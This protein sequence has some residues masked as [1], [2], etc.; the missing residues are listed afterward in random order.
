M[1]KS[2]RVL[3]TPREIAGVASGLQDTLGAR[4][5]E[6]DV[7]LRWTHP[8]AYALRPSRSYL[9]RKLAP[10]VVE[11]EGSSVAR[12]R[13]L[14][15]LVARVMLLP[16]LAARYDAVVFLGQDTFVRGGWDRRLLGRLGVRI[17]TVFCGSE[18]RPPYLDGWYA[19]AGSTTSLDDARSAVTR[20]RERVQ[21]AERDSAAVVNHAGG[22]QFHT[23]PFLDWAVVGFA[24]RQQVVSAAPDSSSAR[25]GAR[26]RVLHAPSDPRMK[27]THEIRAA[28]A[29]LADEGIEFDYVEVSGRSHTEVLELLRGADL[30]VDQLYSDALLPGLAT[31]AA[32]AGTAVLVLGYASGLVADAAARTGAPTAHY[33]H[34]DDLLPR[35]RR[36]LTDSEHRASMAADLHAF[37]TVGHWSLDAIGQRWER[38]VAGDADPDWYDVPT[39]IVYADGCAVSARDDAIFLRRYVERFGA[40]ALELDHHPRL[41]AALLA[42]V[43][44]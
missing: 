24:Q 29:A 27:G 17:I 20:T 26:L 11:T 30:V 39:E 36:L 5:H 44:G 32:R 21:Q 9:L 2:L 28:M 43:E 25:S 23:R 22:A 7:L 41:A 31:E 19:G 14:V 8:F 37:V 13:R 35:V 10:L 6:V 3:V 18:A 1:T 42:R 15:S 12:L 40:R 16:F 38:I 4:G 33:A 34:P